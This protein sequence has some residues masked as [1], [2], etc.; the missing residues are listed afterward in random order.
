M[1]K[2]VST[3]LA[4]IET[5]TAPDAVDF[6]VDGD[7]AKISL[8][9]FDLQ[10]STPLITL[11]VVEMIDKGFTLPYDAQTANFTVGRTVQ[12]KLSHAKATIMSD[13]D[14]LAAVAATTILTFTGVALDGEVVV[15]GGVT[16][17][18]QTVL[19]DTPNFVLIGAAATNSIDNLIAAIENGAGEGTLYGTGTVANPDVNAAVGAGDTMGVTADVAGAAGNAIV[20]TTDLTNASFPAGTL[21]GGLDETTA[22]ILSLKKVS[23]NFMDNEDLEE[24]GFATPGKAVV[25]GAL[26]RVLAVGDA[27]ATI[28]GVA[29]DT[30][31]EF[32]NPDRDAAEAGRYDIYPRRFRLIT[33]EVNTWSAADFA[34]DLIQSGV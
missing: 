31:A 19:T 9:V 25:N 8:Q 7:V 1:S 32:I 15:L 3:I 6:V 21:A 16:Y 33:T 27:W 26:T 17:T 24:V 12:G 2:K 20:S 22:A 13:S 34:V 14:Q 4:A 11:S 30:E 28:T 10:G 18:L 29:V 5:N 23:G